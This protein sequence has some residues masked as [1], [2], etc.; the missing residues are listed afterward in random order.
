MKL[1]PDRAT[2]QKQKL[3]DAIVREVAE[4]LGYGA[5][6]VGFEEVEPA[7]WSARMKGPEIAA[8]WETLLKTPGYGPGPTIDN[9]K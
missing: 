7:D 8:R 5:V 3:T 9:R 4:C 6:L 2:A 1:W